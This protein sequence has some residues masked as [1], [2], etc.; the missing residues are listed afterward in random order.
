MKKIKRISRRSRKKFSFKWLF[1]V[2]IFAVGVSLFSALWSGTGPLSFLAKTADINRL[3]PEEACYIKGAKYTWN[4]SACVLKNAP[5]PAPVVPRQPDRVVRDG[6]ADPVVRPPANAPANLPA[7]PP[8]TLPSNRSTCQGGAAG[9]NIPDGAWASTGAGYGCS[10]ATNCPQRECTQCVNGVWKGSKACNVQ[11]AEN[12]SSVVLP[13]GAGTEYTD[14]KTAAQVRADAANNIAPPPPAK[15]VC[16]IKNEAGVWVNVPS[17]TALT[18]NQ[19]CSDG[20]TV[21]SETYQ[22]DKN[23]EC[24]ISLDNVGA[25][26]SSTTNTCIP[27]VLDPNG[28]IPG[29]PA[30][31][32]CGPGFTPDDTFCKATL[33]GDRMDD[34][35]ASNKARCAR[36]QGV[37]VDKATYDQNTGLCQA[38]TPGRPF[39]CK[40]GSTNSPDGRGY[41]ICGDNDP[42]TSIPLASYRWCPDG[43][44][45]SNNDKQCVA[46]SLRGN[47]GTMGAIFNGKPAC[48]EVCRGQGMKCVQQVSASIFVCVQTP[49]AVDAKLYSG[50]SCEGKC[51]AATQVCQSTGVSGTGAGYFC[52]DKKDAKKLPGAEITDDPDRCQFDGHLVSLGKYKCYCDATKR[53]YTNCSTTGAPSLTTDTPALSATHKANLLN[54]NIPWGTNNPVKVAVGALCPFGSKDEVRSADGKNDLCYPTTA[55]ATPKIRAGG[56]C[57]SGANSACESNDCRFFTAPDGERNWFCMVKESLER[58]ASPDGV[59]NTIEVNGANKTYNNFRCSK[60]SDCLSEFCS[61]LGTLSTN[62]CKDNPFTV[63][64]V[65][66]AELNKTHSKSGCE[67]LRNS[68]PGHICSPIK[69]TDKY[70]LVTPGTTIDEVPPTTTG[71]NT[72]LDPKNTGAGSQATC[73]PNF[74]KDGKGGCKANANTVILDRQAA[75]CNGVYNYNTGICDTSKPKPATQTTTLTPDLKRGPYIAANDQDYTGCARHFNTSCVVGPDGKLYPATTQTSLDTSMAGKQVKDD[76]E[77]G[78]LGS[79]LQ[80][81]IRYCNEPVIT[82]E[83]PNKEPTIIGDN[84][85]RQDLE[86]GSQ[87]GS[88]GYP[89]CNRCEGGIATQYQEGRPSQTQTYNKCG[90]QA[91]VQEILDKD[92]VPER[93]QTIIGDNTSSQTLKTGDVCKDGIFSAVKCNQCPKGLA[94]TIQVEGG[95]I[96]VCGSKEEVADIGTANANKAMKPGNTITGNA[97]I[98]G[99]IGCAT[100]ATAGAIYGAVAGFGVFSPGTALVGGL[101]GCGV[102]LVAGVGI[103]AT[104]TNLA[105]PS[106]VRALKQE[107]DSCGSRIIGLFPV[108]NIGGNDTC[109]SGKCEYRQGIADNGVD[110]FRSGYYCVE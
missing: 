50:P 95:S 40:D 99:G 79:F 13:V 96:Q 90:S 15:A 57:E 72:T 58:H 5:A 17:G 94:T 29:K 45:Y 31:P 106:N 51:N 88:F 22:T 81:N 62:E 82:R 73:G 20:Q 25:T 53:A 21:S 47:T 64:G 54:P 76:S 102:G 100:G 107:G 39:E 32:Q 66:K 12:P 89:S 56:V 48:E 101:V 68:F 59:K 42:K 78:D 14:G 86:I 1:F 10:G 105:E 28:P 30:A 98:G 65:D 77:C 46:P 87:C 49:V 6:Q 44:Y 60:H 103:G 43:Q 61:G 63:G 69:G 38:P 55:P 83:A 71:L 80:N 109:G 23:K 36:E 11:Y 35:N 110:V 91:Q 19:V 41:V 7:N 70:G 75:N 67:A 9:V 108:E 34:I 33:S 18:N 74:I 85:S 3:E 52:I 92:R 4:G 37:A 26:W 104:S 84:S 24:E 2:A 27:K 16:F 8:A 93:Q 97:T